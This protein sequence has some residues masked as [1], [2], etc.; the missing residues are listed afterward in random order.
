MMA[1]AQI[2]DKGSNYCGLSSVEKE[3][4]NAFF[5]ERVKFDVPMKRF[6]TMGVGGPADAVVM[7]GEMSAIE[8]LL[9]WANDR[10]VP[11]YIVGGGSNL[12]IQDGGIRG[13]VMLLPPHFKSISV[14]EKSSRSVKVTVK[15]G[16]RLQA[17]CRTAIEEGWAGMTFAG[18]I[19]AS[20]G[21]AI[22][23]NAGTAE[24]C[25]ADVVASITVLKQDG[26][27]G[28][29]KRND[30]NFD[31][32]RLILPD[33]PAD[34]ITSPAIIL[35]A[36]FRLQLAEPADLAKIALAL[37]KK[38]QS[39]QPEG[40]ASAGCFFKNPTTGPTAGALIDKAG[41]KGKQVGGAQ[42]SNHHANF[43][44]N[45]KDARAAD[46]LTLAEY[47]QTRVADQFGVFLEPEV[48]I[49]GEAIHG[50]KSI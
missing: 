21:G 36:V 19:P 31:Y 29:I 17:L 24:G 18:G 20:V 6:T 40:V 3:Q 23:M 2:R 32:R 49:L 43:I 8:Q 48:V 42:V 39:R 12:I 16:T 50:S 47:V 33:I 9:K 30:L 1:A 4:L 44:I 38:R 7:P 37:K 45:R 34:K 46:V 35:E 13:V 22:V 25:M 10:Q 11:W 27:I 5:R 14:S 28:L 15:T 41:L 26:T